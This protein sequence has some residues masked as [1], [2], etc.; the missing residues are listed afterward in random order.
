MAGKDAL[1][2]AHLHIGDQRQQPDRGDHGPAASLVVSR[3]GDDQP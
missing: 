3:L 2:G 1:I